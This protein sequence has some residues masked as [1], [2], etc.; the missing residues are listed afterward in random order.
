MRTLRVVALPPDEQWHVDERED[1]RCNGNVIVIDNDW[2]GR[3]I[4][5]LPVADQVGRVAVV[6][7]VCVG[8]DNNHGGRGGGTS[9]F[10]PTM[11]TRPRLPRYHHAS[12]PIDVVPVHPIRSR[13][14]QGRGESR[15]LRGRMHVVV[16]ERRRSNPRGMSSPGCATSLSLVIMPFDGEMLVKS[17]CFA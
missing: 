16:L 3:G 2:N 15:I 10:D 9:F 14:I 4:R 12:G 13:T 8:L 1:G 11:P 5:R 17:R 6:V 7:C